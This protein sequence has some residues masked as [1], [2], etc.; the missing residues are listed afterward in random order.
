MIKKEKKPFMKRI[1]AWGLSLITAFISLLLI[2]IFAVIFELLGMSEDNDIVVYFCIG[3]VVALACFLICKAHPKSFWYAP[4]IC[5]AVG[6]LVAF[7]EPNFW[8]TNMW[9]AYGIG[10]IL[11]ILGSLAGVLIGKRGITSGKVNAK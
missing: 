7:I 10:W 4:I 2:F 9:I 8:I 1:P 3:V 11:S 6:I 5:N